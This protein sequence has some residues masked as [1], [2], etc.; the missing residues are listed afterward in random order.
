MAPD[1]KRHKLDQQL[2]EIEGLLKLEI[3]TKSGVEKLVQFYA[4]DPAAQRKAED[5]L[6][7]AERKIKVLQDGMWRI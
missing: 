7:D 1:Q 6:A 4:T 5:E 2:T 3:T